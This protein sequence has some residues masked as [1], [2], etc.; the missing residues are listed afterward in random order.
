MKTLPVCLLSLLVVLMF[1]DGNSWA[2]G[3]RGS[4]G[5]HSGG[6]KAAH[7][8]GGKPHPV[9]H[10][11]MKAVSHHP[12]VTPHKPPKAIHPH[13]PVI[14]HKQVKG[15]IPHPGVIPH[16]PKQVQKNPNVIKP[17][18]IQ[19]AHRPYN[20]IRP[21]NP[22]KLTNLTQ[23]VKT[24]FT[25]THKDVFTPKWWREKSL[26][27]VNN[28]TNI[29][30]YPHWWKHHGPYYWWR[31]CGWA[32]LTGWFA[33]ASW[34]APVNYDYGNYIYY[35]D[36]DVYIHGKRSYSA[37]QYYT[38]VRNIAVTE[39]Q[40]VSENSE[41][42]PLGVFAVQRPNASSPHAIL[43]LAVSKEGAIAGSFYN[44]TTEKTRPAHG[45][46]DKK[47][48]RAAWVVGEGSEAKMVMEAGAYNLTQDRSEVS[49]AFRSE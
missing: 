5:R 40:G 47:T 10:S 46:V 15:P 7:H 29:R 32:G 4:G 24:D 35:R 45:A 13:H 48:Q 20:N 30:W 1:S 43:Q 19:V 21:T 17:H 42:L 22:T 28:I 41:W 31:P 37:P 27:N 6:G 25:P 11:R 23:R 39:P 49:G 16:K 14:P 33:W 18:P 9:H 2:I 3:K 38:V 12:R 26:T 36:D 34:P 8:H 44:V